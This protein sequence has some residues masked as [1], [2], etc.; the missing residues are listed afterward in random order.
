M[1]ADLPTDFAEIA[2]QPDNEMNLAVGALLI[3]TDE[4]PDLDVASY[5]RRLD[6]LAAGVAERLPRGASPETQVG[7]I[8][9]YLFNQR[10]FRGNTEN[11]YD[12]RNSYLNDVLDRRLGI[13]ITLSLVYIEIASR[14]GIPIRGVGLPG[15]FVVKYDAPGVDLYIDAFSGGRVLSSSDCTDFVLQSFGGQLTCL[16]DY[17]TP[18]SH[19]MLLTRMLMNLKLIFMRHGAADRVLR[20]IDKFLQLHPEN[21]EGY[22]ERAQLHINLHHYRAALCDLINYLNLVPNAADAE[23][24]QQQLDVIVSRL[25]PGK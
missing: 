3:A 11:Y 4:Y 9:D 8:N 24:I 13:P 19:R 18:I 23:I 17:L 16:S 22:K 15:H 2:A 20:I 10:R 6:M 14:L 5:V 12:P 1:S 21:A 25:H 7:V